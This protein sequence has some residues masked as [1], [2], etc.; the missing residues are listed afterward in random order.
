MN[1]RTIGITKDAD[2][3]IDEAVSSGLDGKEIM[4]RSIFLADIND[5]K[6]TKPIVEQVIREIMT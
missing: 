1:E 4:R 2:D 3:L 5:S 6:I